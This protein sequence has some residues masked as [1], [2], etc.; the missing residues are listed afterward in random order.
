MQEL[1]GKNN[2]E[3]NPVKEQF[4]IVTNWWRA[5]VEFKALTE[6]ITSKENSCY[7]YV[8]VNSDSTNC[9]LLILADAAVGMRS[10]KR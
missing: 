5:S 10:R 1:M 9:G 2:L 8:H 4:S 6:G 3:I 7:S